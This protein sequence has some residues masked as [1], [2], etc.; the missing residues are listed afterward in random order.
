MGPLVISFLY[1]NFL[2]KISLLRIIPMKIN[3]CVLL[4]THMKGKIVVVLVVVLLIAGGTFYVNKKSNSL[5]KT[6]DA[7]A[8]DIIKF[9]QG[10]IV[11][12]IDSRTVGEYL[13]NSKG[14]TL[15]V[16][17]DDKR[18]ESVCNDD[19]LKKWPIYEFDNKDIPGSADSLS[20]RMNTAK[21]ADSYEQYAYNLSPVYYYIGD[22]KPGD[23]NG[24]SS[25][26]IESKWSLVK[27][28]R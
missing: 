18:L 21:R 3:F 12:S 28:Q 26:D 16:F 13:T 19:C 14:M 15:Y 20:Q 5:N 4:Y 27:I 10:E 7:Q 24:V 25:E 9:T 6:N 22:K 11:G 8:D 17:S 2:K 23:R 1:S